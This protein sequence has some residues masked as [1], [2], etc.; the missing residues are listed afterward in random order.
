MSPVRV[1]LLS[2]VAV[3]HIDSPAE[4]ARRRESRFALGLAAMPWLVAVVTA[5]GVAVGARPT[6]I[7]FNVYLE[8]SEVEIA[9]EIAEVTVVRLVDVHERQ[10]K[11]RAR[12]IVVSS[13]P[14]DFSRDYVRVQSRAIL[15]ED[16]SHFIRLIRI[17]W[18]D[19]V[20]SSR[21]KQR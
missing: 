20:R 19:S 1:T 11:I 4:E 5:G 2:M 14:E 21:T 8:S 7:A 18:F 16:R 13:P 17:A 12:P 3:P 10:G 9:R 6:L 15:S